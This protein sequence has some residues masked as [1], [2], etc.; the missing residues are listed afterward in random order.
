MILDLGLADAE[1]FS[2][3]DEEETKKA[4]D[5]LS[6]EQLHIVDFFCGIRYYKGDPNKKTSL[7]FDYYLLRTIYNRSN[8]EIQIH[9]ERGPRYISPQELTLFIFNRINETLNRKVLKKSHP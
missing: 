8:I 3:I 9:H 7:R 1:G 5:F 4:I 2:Y 6:K